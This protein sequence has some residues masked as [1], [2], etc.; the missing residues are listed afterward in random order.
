M[1]T[2]ANSPRKWVL[3]LAASLA[4]GGVAEAQRQQRPRDRQ[5]PPQA[6]AP[7]SAGQEADWAAPDVP[8]LRLVPS[9]YADGVSEPSGADRP[10]PR[11]ISNI[12][13]DEPEPIPNAQ[14]AS[15]YLW[16]WGQ[17]LDHDI[18]LS[19]TTADE[20]FP[21]AIPAGDLDF[22]PGNTGQVVLFALRSIWDPAS[23]TDA[24]NPRQQLNN[25]TAAIDA[26]NVY[27]SDA[28]RAAALRSNDGTGRLKMSDGD[29]LPFNV[30]GMVNAGG[31]DGDSFVAGDVRVNEQV[32][33]TAMHTVFAREH[34]RLAD[35]IRA[36][37]PGLS[38]DEIYHQA[39]Q[40]V[41]AE[42]QIITY[43]EFLPLLLGPEALGPYRGYR[44]EVDG[45]IAN[46]FSTS[47]YRLGH[48][49][50]NETLLR[51]GSDGGPI[52]AG[53]LPLASAFFFDPQR[54]R[55][56]GGIEPILRGLAGQRARRIDVFVTDALRNFLFGAP[57]AGGFDLASLNIQRGRD[58]GLPDYNSARVALGLAPKTS[59][60]SISSDPDIQSRLEQ[61]YGSVDL[62]DPWVGGLAEDHLAGAMVGEFLSTVLTDQFRR[63]RAGDPQWYERALQPQV[64]QQM[65]R[66]TLGDIIRLNTSI[67]EEI[68]RDVFRASPNAPF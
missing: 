50:L 19:S 14:S 28:E 25:I 1:Q 48:S 43:R 15:A 67:G 22:D 23:G 29:L 38:G 9:D 4:F 3:G 46:L 30:D 16:Q 41:R 18:D 63:L 31:S 24:T 57:G 42:M 6:E 49:M 34:N 60:A 55:A 45:S 21:V 53:H 51:L 52:A 26:S 62:I 36:A 10:N 40:L 2:C 7:V 37:N 17:F 33:L 58:H 47:A 39:R 11:V 64:A 54:L 13:V 32:G 65:E 61:A 35:T 5:P 56:E 27:G 12:V 66:Q 68:P 20:P 59:F 8:L 44:P